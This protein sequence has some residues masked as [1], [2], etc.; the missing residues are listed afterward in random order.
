MI[1][2][3]VVVN[4][5]NS[6]AL[7]LDRRNSRQLKWTFLLP[8]AGDAWK[9]VIEQREPRRVISP[10]LYFTAVLYSVVLEG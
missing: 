3:L 4:F 10:V 9:R 7:I 2:S 5:V 1:T 6:A 8:K